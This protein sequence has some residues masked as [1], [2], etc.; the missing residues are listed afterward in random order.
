MSVSLKNMAILGLSSH[1]MSYMLEFGI[2]LLSNGE[3]WN[4]NCVLLVHLVLGM[5]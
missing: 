3:T 5:I 1:V 2:L 4:Y